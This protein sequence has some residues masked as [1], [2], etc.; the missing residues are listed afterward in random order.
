MDKETKKILAIRGDFLR[1]AKNNLKI[2]N[3]DG[4][5]VNFTPNDSQLVIINHVIKCLDNGEPIRLIVLKARQQG[6]STVIE[7]LIYWWTATHKNIQSTIIA[8]EKDSAQ[9]IYSMFQ[10]YYNNSNPIFQ[11]SH[12]Y[13]TRSDLTFDNDDGTGLKSAISTAT[14]ENTDVGRGKTINWLHCSEVA[15]WK[16]GKEIV[17]GL[18][19]AVPLRPRTA[20]FLESTAHGV[21]GYFYDEWQRAKEGESA[22]TP[23]FFPWHFHREYELHTKE[24]VTYYNKEEKALL[25]IFEREGYPKDSWDAKIKWRRSKL[26][27]IGDPDLF[28][29]EYPSDDVEAFLVSGRPRFN[30]EKLLHMEKQVLPG[31]FYDLLDE[32]DGVKSVKVNQSPLKIWEKPQANK[33]YVIGADVAEGIGGD[34]SVATVMDK[35]AVKTVARFRGDIEP[36]DF[37]DYLDMLGRYYNRALIGCEVNNHGLTTVQRLRDRRY[38]NLYR[39]ERGIDE[40]LESYTQKLGWRTDVKTKPLMINALAEAIYR[41]ELTDYDVVFVR[42]CMTYVVDDRGRTNAQEGR[43]DDTVISVAIALQMFEWSNM[44][45]S[46]MVTPSRLPARYLAKKNRNRQLLRK[47]R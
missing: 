8:H 15:L 27:E 5:L 25:K 41:D 17:A 10:R 19:Q 12:K 26:K 9:F 37:G 36:A 35:D 42:E 6:M 3:K 2:L 21:G 16:K 39:R 7:A 34:Y 24:Q 38:D 13:H 11:P 4:Q 31:K 23:F 46:R 30:T 33:Q 43:H 32:K 20:I 29:Q 14:A 45:R 18:M 47:R 1:Y 22:F 40:R 28:R 44:M